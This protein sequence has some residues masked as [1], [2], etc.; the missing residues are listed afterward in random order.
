MR[1]GSFPCAL[2]LIEFGRA[3]VRV[4]YLRRFGLS[5]SDLQQEHM[6][7]EAAALD[8]VPSC[9]TVTLA[10]EHAAAQSSLEL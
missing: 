7:H 9:R 3:D 10:A 6:L 2:V 8:H 4:V 1:S 5:V